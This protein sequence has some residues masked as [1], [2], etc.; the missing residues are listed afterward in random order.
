MQ[1]QIQ[2]YHQ[3]MQFPCDINMMEH[4]LTFDLP[5]NNSILQVVPNDTRDFITETCLPRHIL[6]QEDKV[7][8]NKILDLRGQLDEDSDDDAIDMNIH[9]LS[10]A[11]LDDVDLEESEAIE[12]EVDHSFILLTLANLS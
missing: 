8:T 2:A 5:T 11:E 9:I 6:Q 1:R 12:R 4:A 3:H 10:Q 7:S